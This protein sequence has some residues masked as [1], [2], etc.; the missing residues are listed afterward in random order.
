VCRKTVAVNYSS[1]TVVNIGPMAR[2]P[3]ALTR[4]AWRSER[5]D[6]QP[7]VLILAWN[8]QRGQ[9]C[10]AQPYAGQS[11]SRNATRVRECV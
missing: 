2:I 10:I 4:D 7:Q 3:Q 5:L 9:V 6:V 1:R 8:A 11:A